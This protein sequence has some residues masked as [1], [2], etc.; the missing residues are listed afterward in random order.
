MMMISVMVLKFE[1]TVKIDQI[2]WLHSFENIKCQYYGNEIKYEAEI[3]YQDEIFDADIDYCIEI[4]IN[5]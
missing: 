4:L 1:S 5:R 2:S 3:W